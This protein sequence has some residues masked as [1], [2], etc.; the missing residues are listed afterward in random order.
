MA[1][2]SRGSCR[3]DTLLR[4]NGHYVLWD[5]TEAALRGEARWMSA[6]TGTAHFHAIDED[7]RDT[8]ARLL[9]RSPAGGIRFRQ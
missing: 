1:P 5:T 3:D 9:G 8:L 7:E 4:E 2:S 6:D